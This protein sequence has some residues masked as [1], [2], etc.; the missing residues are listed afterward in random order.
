MTQNSFGAPGLERLRSSI[1]GLDTVLGGGFFRSGVYI[2]QGLP[3][4]GKTIFANQ[5][6][7]GHVTA[8]GR[9]VYVTL[10][11][12]SHARMLQHIRPLDF[13]DESM[14]PTRLTYMSAFKELEMEGLKG[15]TA[16]LRR[17]MRALN[18]TVLVL[19][20]LVAATEAAETDRELK[21]FIH[22]IQTNAVFH[23]CTVFLL[24]SG[25][26]QRINAEHTMVDG[27]IELEDRLFDARSERAIQVRKFRGGKALRGKHG[28]QITDA[29]LQVFPRIEALFTQP[30]VKDAGLPEVLSTGVPS[31]DAL[32]QRGGLP[33]ASATVVIG[34][35]GTGKTTMGLQ[36]VSRSSAQEPGLLFG[37]FESPDR[38]RTHAAA[39]GMPIDRLE[40]EGHLHLM[41][42]SQG[43]HVLD[44]LAHKLL[45]K[46]QAH[47]V[48]RLTIDGLSGF[49]ENATYPER[50]GR[51]FS[52][53]VNELRRRGVTV[54]MTLETRDAVGSMVPTPYGI[55]AFVDN[56]M[57]LRFVEA[58]GEVK[59]LISI[60]KIRSS[61]F[62]PGL[63]ALETAAS[64]LRVSGRFTASGD[65]IPSAEAV[66]RST[67]TDS[68]SEDPK[69]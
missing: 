53:L 22:E 39:L 32:I 52:G 55:S 1:P 11:A 14:I 15:L 4:C 44:E 21:K 7:Y 24:T 20:G 19:D 58:K 56:L 35:T 26:S 64:G 45:D 3:G 8:G 49:L 17:E 66:D 30:G 62:D 59:R 67:S 63:Y 46:V 12:E 65:I 57:F 36:F 69:R 29:G 6:C 28:F 27:I 25:T 10:L 48:R 2:L 33:A 13:Y 38:L 43:E 31:L 47:G 51:F 37:F 18:A 23:G 34:S 60:L 42:H 61:H 50:I 68:V 16:L 41:W 40:A 9:A 5:L 54:L